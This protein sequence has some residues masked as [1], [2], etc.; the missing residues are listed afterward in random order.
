MSFRVYEFKPINWPILSG[1]ELENISG[2]RGKIRISVSL[3]KHGDIPAYVDDEHLTFEFESKEIEVPLNELHNILDEPRKVCVIDPATNHIYRAAIFDRH[4]YQLVV[5]AKDVEP[6]IEID[7]IHMHG[8][9]DTTPLREAREKVELLHIKPKEKVLDI[10]TGLGYT[11]TWEIKFGAKVITIEKDENVLRL[12]E[13]NPWSS[14]L[15]YARIIVGDAVE[16]IPQLK[17]Q[18]FDKI[19]HDPPRLTNESGYLYSRDFYAELFRILRRGGL[20]FHYVGTPHASK[21]RGRKRIL[22]GVCRRLSSVGFHVIKVIRDK[23]RGWILA[24]KPR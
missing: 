13:F 21:R 9:K 18:S 15:R 1:F 23:R 10:C 14:H 12:A 20:L 2:K 7:G 17:S 16:I 3:G 19:L 6:T 22:E 24:K 8:I 4:F 11:A 5:P